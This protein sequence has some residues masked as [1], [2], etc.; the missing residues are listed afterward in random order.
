MVNLYTR[1]SVSALSATAILYS[2]DCLSQLEAVGQRSQCPYGMHFMPFYESEV[3][4]NIN[5]FVSPLVHH[6]KAST[7]MYICFNVSLPTF[8]LTF[9]NDAGLTNEKHIK[10]TS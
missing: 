7:Y 9:S 6:N 3:T 10:N 4:W 2:F 5:D 1:S 8:A